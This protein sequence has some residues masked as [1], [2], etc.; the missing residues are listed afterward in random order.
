MMEEKRKKE[1]RERRGGG[2]GKKEKK[3]LFR[4]RRTALEEYRTTNPEYGKM[5]QWRR[6]GSAQSFL[7]VKKQGPCVARRL[8]ACKKS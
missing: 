6:V 4:D 3:I 1:S 2:R 5:T 8:I 7:R